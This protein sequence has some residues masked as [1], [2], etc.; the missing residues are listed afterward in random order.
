MVVFFENYRQKVFIV[1]HT[2]ENRQKNEI[3]AYTHKL[4]PVE[5][6]RFD[7]VYLFALLWAITITLRSG[8]F[9]LN[10]FS[11]HLTA[12]ILLPFLGSGCSTRQR[13][14]RNLRNTN[15]YAKGVQ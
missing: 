4:D 2:L 1:R 7:W 11:F 9:T 5:P 6:I 13:E 14:Y 8:D 12:R 10:L 3:L 15:E